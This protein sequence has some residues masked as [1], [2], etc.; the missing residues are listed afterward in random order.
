MNIP[1][2]GREKW[3]KTSLLLEYKGVFLCH[4]CQ[5]INGTRDTYTCHMGILFQTRNMGIT[6]GVPLSYYFDPIG[7]SVLLEMLH[8]ETCLSRDNNCTISLFC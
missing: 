5:D 6:W 4:K 1:P 8:E 7:P 2:P 3:G